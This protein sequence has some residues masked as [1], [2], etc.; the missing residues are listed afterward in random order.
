NGSTRGPARCG[1][2][3]PWRGEASI[4]SAAPAGGVGP[5]P[6]GGRDERYRTSGG[7]GPASGRAI[8]RTPDGRRTPAGKGSRRKGRGRILRP[9]IESAP[10]QLPDR[11]SPWD[12]Q[13]MREHK[14]F[15]FDTDLALRQG[16]ATHDRRGPLYG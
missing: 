5:W 11:I 15:L 8:A 9:R 10:N 4:T 13:A 3:G 7:H 12:T 1:R 6:S 16:V 2:R 14:A